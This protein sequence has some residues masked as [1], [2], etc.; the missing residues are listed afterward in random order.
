V[1]GRPLPA[2]FRELGYGGWRDV[3]SAERLLEAARE[4]VGP[5]RAGWSR[6]GFNDLAVAVAAA[7]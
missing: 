3:A 6:D 7:S 4:R 2:R 5:D 1:A